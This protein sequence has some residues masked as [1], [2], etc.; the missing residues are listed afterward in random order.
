MWRI[1]SKGYLGWYNLLSQVKT[2]K[3]P[4][5]PWHLE[6]M[7]NG[8]PFEMQANIRNMC[9]GIRG[10][11]VGCYRLNRISQSVHEKDRKEEKNEIKRKKTGGPEPPGAGV[12]GAGQASCPRHGLN[13]MQAVMNASE[14]AK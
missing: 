13:R 7:G 9:P 12:L 2:M 4:Q 11:H 3:N 10:A 5:K 6:P 14:G 1:L 8:S